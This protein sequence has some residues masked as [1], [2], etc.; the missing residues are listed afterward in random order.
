M[1]DVNQAAVQP[2]PIAIPPFGGDGAG[3]ADLRRWSPPTWSAPASSGR[4]TRRPSA[5]AR[6]STSQPTFDAWKAIS[7]QALLVGNVTTGADGRLSVDFRL[8]DVY[9]GDQLVGTRLTATPENWRTHRPQDRRR[10]L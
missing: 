5:R 9:A 8:W 10:G 4:S 6:T 3:R 7:A 1:V 2:L